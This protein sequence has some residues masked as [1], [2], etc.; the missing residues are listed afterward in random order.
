MGKKNNRIFYQIAYK[1]LKSINKKLILVKESYTSKCDTPGLELIGYYDIYQGRKSKKKD[2]LNP[3][4]K[5]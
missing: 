1:K 2:Y 3:Q 5:N 4:Q